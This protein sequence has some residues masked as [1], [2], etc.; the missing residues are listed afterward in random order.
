MTYQPTGTLS[1]CFDIMGFGIAVRP[2]DDDNPSLGTSKNCSPF[3]LHP[4]RN[5]AHNWG[6]EMD[7]CHMRRRKYLGV[8]ITGLT[9]S[10]RIGNFNTVLPSTSLSRH[11]THGSSKSTFID[12]MQGDKHLVW[13]PLLDA[14]SPTGSSVSSSVIS[15]P[16]SPQVKCTSSLATVGPNVRCKT[17]GIL[18]WCLTALLPPCL[19]VCT[20][21][22]RSRG[23]LR[24]VDQMQS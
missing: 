9:K 16:S 8:A 3:D 4:I 12:F 7:A 24:S 6:K 23:C 17:L 10:S 11:T 20:V 19:S 15:P 13:S 22:D 14:G 2:V 18:R 21:E 1:F 5:G